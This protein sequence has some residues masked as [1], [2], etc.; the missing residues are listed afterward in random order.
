M[1]TITVKQI[2]VMNKIK[3]FGGLAYAWN[4]LTAKW[5]YNMNTVKALE[6][7]G[8]IEIRVL[9]RRTALIIT[10]IGYKMLDESAVT[11]E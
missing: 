11:I 1:K 5:N 9:K 4:N 10:E 3:F 8:C 2:E 7:K 6:R